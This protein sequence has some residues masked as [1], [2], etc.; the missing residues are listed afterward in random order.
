MRDLLAQTA[1]GDT[2]DGHPAGEW[3]TV[4]WFT[5]DYRPWAQKLIA[6]LEA[7]GAPHDFV[8]V[9]KL[10]GGWEAN[11][12]AKARHVLDAMDRHSGKVLIFLDADCEVRGDLAPLATGTRGDVA[13]L[14]PVKV[15]RRGV[16]VKVLSGTLVIRPTAGARRFVEAWVAASQKATW[17]DID[18]T[19]LAIAMATTPGITVEPLERKWCAVIDHHAPDSVIL[20]DN[21]SR[22]ERKVKN[23]WHRLWWAWSRIRSRPPAQL[24]T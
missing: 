5:P 11:T 12:M 20:H 9:P 2:G 22:E 19:T 18:Q 1:A 3:I 16:R 7:V 17:G 6:S 14:L 10:P 21:A 24:W 13:F 15:K 4:G 23:T 8:E